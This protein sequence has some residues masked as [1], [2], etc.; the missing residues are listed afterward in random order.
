MGM[1]L[2]EASRFFGID[3]EALRQMQ[4]DGLIGERV[5]QEQVNMLTFLQNIWASPQY[6]RFQIRKLQPAVRK[7][8][9][10]D[11]SLSRMEKYI[12]TRYVNLK[13][14][15]RLSV[16]DL[17]V[18]LRN[19]FGAS[20]SRNLTEKI[21]KIRKMARDERRKKKPKGARDDE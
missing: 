16:D 7:K 2:E 15:D 13:K 8:L 3:I 12:F 6:L 18:E 11:R 4:K 9:F 20:L 17:A 14:G 21:Q 19:R 10:E 1:V 5:N